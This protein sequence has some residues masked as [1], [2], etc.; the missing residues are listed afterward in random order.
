M[1]NNEQMEAIESEVLAMLEIMQRVHD[2]ASRA[3][4]CPVT[5]VG[6]NYRVARHEQLQDALDELRDLINE[7]WRYTP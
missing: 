6:V 1:E 2:T 5:A 4:Y 7:D 3:M